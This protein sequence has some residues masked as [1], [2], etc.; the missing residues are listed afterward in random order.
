MCPEQKPA[1][2]RKA[3][4]KRAKNKLATRVGAIAA[5]RQD[6]TLGDEIVKLAQV[7]YMCSLPHSQTPEGKVTRRVRLSDGSKLTVTFSSMLDG[8]PLPYGRDR[9]L[10]AWIFDRAIRNGSAFVPWSAAS[11]YQRE[12]GLTEGGSSNQNLRA[13]FKRI[14]GLGIAITRER[15]GV[16]RT[17]GYKVLLDSNLPS[18]IAGNVINAN[19]TTLPGMEVAQMGISL[20]PELFTDISRHNSVLPRLIW[21]R[22]TGPSQVQDIALWLFVRCYAA[23]SETVIPWSAFQEQFGGEDSNPRRIKAN[24]RLAI[25]LLRTIWPG[26]VIN[27][28]ENGVRVAKANQAL[29]PDDPSR[30]RIRKL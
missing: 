11:E 22:I 29:L 4:A 17:R 24:A 6:G 7:L 19:Q 15:D 8:V 30:G 10:L 9:K 20:S 27:E 1:R 18:S 28:D 23:A 3:E 21:Q 14:A 25:T 12:M 13:R 26:A 2:D 5:A 16:E